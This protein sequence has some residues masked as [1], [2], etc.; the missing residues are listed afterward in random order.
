MSH[1]PPD[2]ESVN[3]DNDSGTFHRKS[4]EGLYW[5]DKFNEQQICFDYESDNFCPEDEF[6]PTWAPREFPGQRERKTRQTTLLAYA[7]RASLPKSYRELATAVYPKAFDSRQGNHTQYWDGYKYI[8]TVTET[9]R[10]Y[11]HKTKA[12]VRC[13]YQKVRKRLLECQTLDE[14]LAYLREEAALLI[15]VDEGSN[16][17]WLY[18][19]QGPDLS[20]PSE[21]IE[22]ARDL[23]LKHKDDQSLPQ[24]LMQ[25]LFNATTNPSGAQIDPLDYPDDNDQQQLDFGT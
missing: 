16:G 5:Q 17:E 11:I 15:P 13:I 9:Q 24:D 10:R 8:D 12:L 21:I 23:M 3:D 4:E 25:K 7:K 19:Y 1:N 14:E 2:F 20:Q 6:L 22:A 18:T